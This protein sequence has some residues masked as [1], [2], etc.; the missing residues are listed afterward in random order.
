MA[1]DDSP[2]MIVEDDAQDAALVKESFAA[3]GWPM[4]IADTGEQA[5]TMLRTAP[6]LPRCVLLDLHLLGHLDGFDTL[7][8]IRSNEKTR[9]IPVII[10]TASYTREDLIQ[11]FELGAASVIRRP[12]Q[13]PAKVLALVE[14]FIGDLDNRLR[15]ARVQVKRQFLELQARAEGDVT[16]PSMFPS[17]P[18]SVVPSG[19]QELGHVAVGR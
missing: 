18:V 13:S 2:V 8:L 3:H 17:A 14:W 6:K 9:R 15:N 11:A 1:L 5:L 16:T 10:Y 12:V 7:R 19:I 4:V